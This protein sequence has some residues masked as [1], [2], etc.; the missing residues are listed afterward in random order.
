M[1]IAKLSVGL[2]QPLSRGFDSSGEYVVVMDAD[3]QHP[4]DMLPAIYQRLQDGIDIVI[5]S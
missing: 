5:P 1:F 2:Q 3:I 4:P